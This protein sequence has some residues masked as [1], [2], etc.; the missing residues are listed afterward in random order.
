MKIGIVYGRCSSTFRTDGFDIENLYDAMGLTG[1]ESTYF[2][3]VRGLQDLGHEVH[4]YCKT[5][6]TGPQSRLGGATVYNLFAQPIRTDLDAYISFNEPDELQNIVGVPRICAQQ[7]ND[8]S[9]CQHNWLS[10]CDLIVVPSATLRDY[11]ARKNGLPFDRF[12]VIGNSINLEFSEPDPSLKRRPLS[13]AWCSSPDRG[14]HRLL[15]I[16]PFLRA[17]HPGTTLRV[18]YRVMPWLERACGSN[19][20]IGRRARY[21]RE[22][23]RKN[24]TEG[25]NGVFLVDAIPNKQ[26]ARELQ[27]TMV[28]A[29]PCDP[30]QFTE[31][32]G[33]SVLDA[34]A[35]GCVP[36]V[37]DADAFREIYAE[38]AVMIQ[39]PP[40][41][42]RELWA[43]TIG[44]YLTQEAKLYRKN[45]RLF[46]SQY[47]RDKIARQWEALLLE[48]TGLGP[49]RE[50]LPPI[51]LEPLVQIDEPP[52]PLSTT[53]AVSAVR[54]LWRE[55]LVHDEVVN[56]RR[57]LDSAPWR[58]RYHPELD[59]MR[60][61]TDAMLAHFKDAK[62][63][64][65][66][67]KN[68]TI[69]APSYPLELE[70]TSPDSV[71]RFSAV[72]ETVDAALRV[73]ET[74]DVLDLGCGDGWV[75]N[76]LAQKQNVRAFGV[77][78]SQSAVKLAKAQAEEHKTGA[79]FAEAL[80]DVDMSW[81][82]KGWPQKFDVVSCLEMY[83][84]VKEPLDLLSVLFF[85]LKPGGR[86]VLSTP[87]GSWCQ[88]RQIPWHERWNLETPR[89]HVRAPVPEDVLAELREIGFCDVRYEIRE[90]KMDIPGQATL[91]CWASRP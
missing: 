24:G 20:K 60:K 4:A 46:A 1:S 76:R 32:F 87:H 42:S 3:L 84:H 27:Q 75:T 64:Q 49:K 63:Y 88:G 5:A 54:L 77:D 78:W 86:L 48:K 67:Y 89:E 13:I 11:L 70:V 55:L 74:V 21:I 36:I 83:E 14:L 33:V 73:S 43:Q 52:F 25:E 40:K 16:F 7:L 51:R 58:V 91:V 23:F 72:I 18:Y 15:E 66:L 82:P 22:F 10:H 56:A 6:H 30:V 44:T 19:D 62:T 90:I 2:N 34:C 45:L 9:Y 26:M 29:Y 71:P 35:A 28:L 81:I 65:D 57:L 50:V 17:N 85:S 47:S 37:S 38:H 80:A 69:A 59:N 39:G 79:Q 41:L 12:E 61:M 31:G 53:Q 68:Y 8:F